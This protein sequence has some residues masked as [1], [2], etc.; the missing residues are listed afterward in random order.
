MEC[1]P[2]SAT[3]ACRFEDPYHKAGV[4][5]GRVRSRDGLS[6]WH[7]AEPRRRRSFSTADPVNPTL[8]QGRDL[9]GM[10][11]REFL[12]IRFP[13]FPKAGIA[14]RGCADVCEK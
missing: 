1:R 13:L 9:F 10:P 8:Y 6:Q 14:M 4:S 12:I 11:A 3:F 2:S 5:E 7:P